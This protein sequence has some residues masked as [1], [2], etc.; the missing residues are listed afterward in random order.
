MNLKKMVLLVSMVAAAVA[1]I[2]LEPTQKIAAERK[3][4]ILANIIP[5]QFGEW[6]LIDSS[7]GGRIVNPE[8]NTLINKLYSQTLSRTYAN[9]KGEQVMLVIAYGE[10]QSDGTQLHYPEVCYPAQGFQ[11]ISADNT[12]LNTSLGSIPVRKLIATFSTRVEPI[13]YWTTI[14]NRAVFRGKETRLLKLSYGL[15]GK[16]P[17]GILFRTSSITADT[18]HGFELQISFINNLLSALPAN[19]LNAI[20]GL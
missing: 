9:S 20:A 2:Y 5:L 17:D 14:G 10:D 1:A 6:K 15:Q 3:N 11:I 13:I 19:N 18:T 12:L 8:Q 16:I 7:E 4:F